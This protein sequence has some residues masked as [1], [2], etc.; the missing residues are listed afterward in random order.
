MPDR[1]KQVE[2]YF[3]D[4]VK[5]Y[6]RLYDSGGDADLSRYPGGPVRLQKAIALLQRFKPA[7]VVLDVG[8]GTGHTALAAAKLGY[9]VIGLDLS[10]Q[11]VE[12]ST[13]LLA[14][15]GFGERS[16]FKTADVE[17]MPID[18]GSVDGVLALG[19]IEYLTDDARFVAEV[20]RVL[21]PGGVAVIAFR[22]RLFNLFSMNAYTK[23][24]IDAGEQGRLLQEFNDEVQASAGAGKVDYA[25]FAAELARRAPELSRQKSSGNQVKLKPLPIH[26]RQHTPREARDAFAQSGFKCLA[27]DYFHFHPF[28]P[29]FESSGP[30][31]FNTLGLAMETLGATPIGALMASAFLCVFQAP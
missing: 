19:L 1:K 4:I 10:S 18:N 7:G 29:A 15:E 16:S 27:T 31:L 2:G 28:P 6:A 11:M 22:N 5:D 8:C 24:E 12:Q 3:D 25:P 26:L 20:R 9:R 30:A 14:R 17:N 23:Q 21:R 13:Q